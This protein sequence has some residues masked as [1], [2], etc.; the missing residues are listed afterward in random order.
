MASCSAPCIPG[1]VSSPTGRCRTSSPTFG[2]FLNKAN[3][4]MLHGLMD[5]PLVDESQAVVAIL[6]HSLKVFAHRPT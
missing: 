1:E 6:R 4:L 2:F 5:F 3:D